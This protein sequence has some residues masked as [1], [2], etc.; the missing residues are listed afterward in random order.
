VA[1]EPRGVNLFAALHRTTDDDL[2]PQPSDD[3]LLAWAD[4]LKRQP[5]RRR[6]LVADPVSAY[7]R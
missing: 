3:D 6:Q 7:A 5:P 4:E 1:I 2:P